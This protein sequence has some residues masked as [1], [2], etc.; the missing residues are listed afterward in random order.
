[1]YR[2]TLVLLGLAVLPMSVRAQDSEET[3][4]VKALFAQLQPVSI[5]KNREYC[6]YIGLDEA[7]VLTSS[8][9]KKGRAGSCTPKDPKELVT[10]LASYH[11]HG[12]YSPNY[13][14]EV[15][16]GDDMEGDEAEGI[17][18]W[19]ATPGG[20]LWYIDT[21]DMVAAQVCGLGCVASDPEFVAGDMGPIQDSYSYDELVQTLEKLDAE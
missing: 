1:M 6:G 10:I 12:A 17:D 21:Q 3:A 8:K 13:Y 2:L 14:N 4:F 18:G 11:T 20:R 15:P 19:V 16:S 7:G 9:P 5:D